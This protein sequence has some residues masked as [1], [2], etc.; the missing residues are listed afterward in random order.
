MLKNRQV[1]KQKQRD[2]DLR[3]LESGEISKEEL[4]KENGFFSSLPLNK[5]KIKFIGNKI[6]KCIR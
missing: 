6:L 5:F 4:K 3:R 2:E 1:K